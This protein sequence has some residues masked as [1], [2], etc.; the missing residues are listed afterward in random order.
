MNLG[1]IKADVHFL[2]GSASGTYS[3]T[4]IVRNVNIEYQN[5]ANLIW[6]SCGDWQYDDSNATTL[7]VSRTTMV[8]NQQDYTLPST[9]QRVHRV[10][11]KD[12]GGNWIKL[13]PLDI[14]GN[15]Q[16]MPEIL[17]GTAGTPL[18]Y[19]LVGRSVLLYPI[20]HSGYTTL[21]SGLA[22]YIDRDVTEFATTATTT[23]PGFAT[24]FHRILSYAASIDF[25]QDDTQRQR[26]VEQKARLEEQM[27]RFYS[28]RAVEM[29][30]RIKPS[31]KKF[32][33]Q[34]L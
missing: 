17:G 30:T 18:Y 16:A 34:Y 6:Q 31:G 15:P 26:L 19:D 29:K 27:K 25:I 1:Q 23:V 22:V 33:R 24:P 10:E 14:H 5:V 11:I 8:H 13:Q 20:P 21:A 32:W 28:K 3:D 9:A 7:P 2:C 12:S 4:N